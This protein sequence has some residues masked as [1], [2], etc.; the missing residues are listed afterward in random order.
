MALLGAAALFAG[1]YGSSGTVSV[2]VSGYGY[3]YYGPY[4]GYGGWGGWGGYPYGGGGVVIT[5]RPYVSP[6]PMDDQK[7]IESDR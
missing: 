7:E 6:R 5:G 2:G 1:C 4:G 3:P